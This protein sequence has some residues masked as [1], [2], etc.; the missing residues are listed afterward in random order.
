VESSSDAG[1]GYCR[2][3]GRRIPPRDGFC[4]YC[5]KPNSILEETSVITGGPGMSKIGGAFLIVSAMFSLISIPIILNIFRNDNLDGNQF[6]YFLR[7]AFSGLLSNTVDYVLGAL[8]IFAVISIIG[9]LSAIVGGSYTWAFVG[10]LA[11]VFSVAGIIGLA[12][13][14]L[15]TTSKNDFESS[16]K[17]TSSG[18]GPQGPLGPLSPRG[19]ERDPAESIK[20]S[21]LARR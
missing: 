19:Q 18:L 14:I 4:F 9:G 6:D 21:M 3:C 11:S 20:D 1:E 5:G 15:I 10:G 13:L 12:G 16:H 8:A 2:S 7:I 17:D